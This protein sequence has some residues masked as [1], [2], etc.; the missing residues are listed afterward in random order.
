MGNNK[1]I[2]EIRLGRIKAV[3]WGNELEGGG[4]RHNVQVRRIYKDGEE[5]KQS[6]SFGRDDLP[7]VAKV[8]D[9]AHT[10]IHQASQDEQEGQGR[11]AA[12]PSASPGR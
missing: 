2:H 12:R 9:M 6:D 10:W 8:A 4:F 3:I 11:K 1:P 5:W 7:L